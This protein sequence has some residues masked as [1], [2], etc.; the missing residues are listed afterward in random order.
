MIHSKSISLITKSSI[1]FV[2]ISI[3]TH[4]ACLDNGID[5][6]SLKTLIV[7]S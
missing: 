2:I 1:L 4:R 5:S 6:L 7:L 3:R